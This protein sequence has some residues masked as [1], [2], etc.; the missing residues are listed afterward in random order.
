M[1]LDDDIE[2]SASELTTFFDLFVRADLN[3]VLAQPSL[4]P[5]SETAWWETVIQRDRMLLHYTSFVELMAPTASVE[6]FK[7]VIAPTLNE[8]Y[9]GWGLDFIWPFLAGFP[10]DQVGVVDAVCMRHSYGKRGV[11]SANGAKWSPSEEWRIHIDRWNMTPEGVAEAGLE[12]NRP[13]VFNEL[14]LDGTVSVFFNFFESN[15]HMF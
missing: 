11:Y 9:F 14:P 10:R 6:F 15:H 13:H 12:W 3:L 2:I 4:C 5:G 1:I 7:T 8:S